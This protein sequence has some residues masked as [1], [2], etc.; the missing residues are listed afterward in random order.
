ML[1]GKGLW[2]RY[3]YYRLLK[4]ENAWSSPKTVGRICE[5]CVDKTKKEAEAED[6]P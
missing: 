2:A 5:E 1:C 6:L 3:P 4:Q